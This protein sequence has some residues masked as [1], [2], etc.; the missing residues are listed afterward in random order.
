MLIVALLAVL[1]CGCTYVPMDVR[2]PPERLRSTVAD[3]G[4][5]DRL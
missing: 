5:L 3:A 2:H 4:C 1:K